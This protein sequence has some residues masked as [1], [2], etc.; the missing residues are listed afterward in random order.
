MISSNLLQSRN[1]HQAQVKAVKVKSQ[2]AAESEQEFWWK[3]FSTLSALIIFAVILW[4]LGYK[5]WHWLDRPIT[6]VE[7]I[8]ELQHV[9]QK[10]L[11]AHITK[12]LKDSLL[13]VNIK[14]IQQQLIG[15]PWVR[16]AAIARHWPGT[17]IINIE[18]EFPIARWGE[19][20][21]LNHRG[22]IFWP[23][24]KDEDKALPRLSGPKRDTVR[25]MS[26][27]HDLNHILRPSGLKVTSLN[28]QTRGA[29]DFE[30]NN[31]IKI[32]MGRTDIDKRLQRFLKIYSSGLS[33]KQQYIEQIDI[34]YTH[35]I[36]V[37]WKQ[38]MENEIQ[39]T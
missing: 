37:K 15:H 2:A 20:G 8:G 3:P 35:G 18:E 38:E 30:L 14:S 19:H 17:L 1:K 32:E 39:D 22:D 11:V 27:F 4:S 6:K 10:E 9:G 23:E 7:I 5:L 34:R 28:L 16:V 25:V 24:L 13:D 31:Q 21:L 29:W 12:N 36:A 33:E 26:Q